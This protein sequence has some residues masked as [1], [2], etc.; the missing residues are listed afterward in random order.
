MITWAHDSDSVYLVFHSND[1]KV[2]HCVES[3][4]GLITTTNLPV[5]E[6]FQSRELLQAWIDNL[7]RFP[8]INL[9]GASFSEDLDNEERP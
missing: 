8:E 4:V 5:K 6:T 2:V 1:K 7:E 3:K 9:G